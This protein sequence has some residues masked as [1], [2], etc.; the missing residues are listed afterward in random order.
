MIEPR[1]IIDKDK[2]IEVRATEVRVRMAKDDDWQALVPSAVADYITDNDLDRRFQI[3][4]GQEALNK[5]SEENYK[6]LETLEEQIKHT[7]ER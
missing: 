7:Y 4:F 3:Q 6:R 5:H 1:D 2:Q